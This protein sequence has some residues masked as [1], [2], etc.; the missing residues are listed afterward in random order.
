ALA[1]VGA[2]RLLA[3]RVEGLI[4][5]EHPQRARRRVEGAALPRP[6]GK[7]LSRDQR[8]GHEV[9]S[10]ASGGIHSRRERGGSR[11]RAARAPLLLDAA[12]GGSGGCAA[13]TPEPASHKLRAERDS[14]PRSARGFKGVRRSTPLLNF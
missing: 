7:A 8:S 13:S 10:C 6:L 12:S 11:G 2:A 9:T 4:A 5:E 14:L 3:D 1:E